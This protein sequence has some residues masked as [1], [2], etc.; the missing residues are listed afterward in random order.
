MSVQL[1]EVRAVVSPPLINWLKHKSYALFQMQGV[2]IRLYYLHT[3][4][5]ENHALPPPALPASFQ[6]L[7]SKCRSGQIWQD[8][9][10]A[11]VQ[12]QLQNEETVQTLPV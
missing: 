3:K 8:W 12:P 5:G 1:R 6:N 4:Y 7:V 11:H 9:I 2:H 10:C